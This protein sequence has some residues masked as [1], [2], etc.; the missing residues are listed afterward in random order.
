[1]NLDILYKGFQFIQISWVEECKNAIYFVEPLILY[2]GDLPSLDILYYR[3][4]LNIKYPRI[5][6]SYHNSGI[7]KDIF[8][9]QVHKI[10]LTKNSKNSCNIFLIQNSGNFVWKKFPQI[11][12]LL[13]AVFMTFT[14]IFWPLLCFKLT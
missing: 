10:L 5:T 13:W 9:K 8:I 4:T 1:M 3:V 11:I 12:I 2:V 14:L 6:I 7:F